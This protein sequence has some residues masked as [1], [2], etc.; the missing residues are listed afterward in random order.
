M[1]LFGV[2]QVSTRRRPLRYEISVED[3]TEVD[4]REHDWRFNL[5]KHGRQTNVLYICYTPSKLLN[6]LAIQVDRFLITFDY[7]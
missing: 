7:F 3:Q 5:P 2:A 1:V 4:P 6:L